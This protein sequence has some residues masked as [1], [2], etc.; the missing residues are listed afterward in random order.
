M[1]T[2]G[3]Y[4]IIKELGRGGFGTVYEAVDTVLERPVAL[5]VLHPN[6]VNDLSFVSR[7]RQEAKLAA[8][9][10]HPNIVPVH[11]FDQKDGRFFIAMGLMP[12]GS[13]KDLLTESGTLNPDQCKKILLHISSGLAYAHQRDII[14]RDLKPGNILI[15]EHGIARVSDFGFAKA[16]TVANSLSM[17][18][19]GGL[20]GTPAY[21][22]PEI[23]DG[24]EAS[25]QSDIY[26]LGC[27]AHELLTGKPLFEG[28]SAAKIMT[29]HVIYG[30][31]LAEE[32]DDNWRSFLMRCLAKNP[33]DRYSSFDALVE[34]LY[35]DFDK[36]VVSNNLEESEEEKP[37][38]SSDE[39]QDINE[40]IPL[41]DEKPREMNK[42]AESIQF[43]KDKSSGF[44]SVIIGLIFFIGVALLGFFVNRANNNL[45]NNTG[46]STQTYRVLTRAKDDMKMIY[47]PAGKFTMG[48]DSSRS[49]SDE[50]PKRE[51]T[52]KAY[53]ID[54][55]EVTNRQYALCV[56]KGVCSMPS[57]TKSST[58]SSYYGNTNYDNYPVINVSWAQASAYCQWVG[59]ELPTEAQWEKAARGENGNKYPWGNKKPNSN[60]AN[61]DGNMGDT[62]AVGSYPNGASPY[63]VM[64]MAGNVWEWVRDWYK[65]SYDENQT[66]NPIGPAKGGSRVIRGGGWG[67]TS[68]DVRSAY[69]YFSSPRDTRNDVGFRCVS[70]P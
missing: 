15:D 49:Y 65:D 16:M 24:E 57:L 68:W 1:T 5:K 32:L 7:F 18:M 17:N 21:M 31:K 55:Y 37:S 51:V 46:I 59:G 30:P 26:S 38:S 35:R 70:P 23:W 28:D 14:H 19:T 22:A 4:E 27:I 66:N 33:A 62:T 20:L 42:S 60:L 53:L 69:R 52:L 45:F 43:I 54:Q 34:A 12:K 64:D 61:Y 10:E 39:I 9:L 11:D 40:L 3:K 63:G 6:L 44:A 13:I 41:S 36:N 25:P 2:L 29:Q 8:K 56:N 50:K 58:R 47:I 67:L 48:S